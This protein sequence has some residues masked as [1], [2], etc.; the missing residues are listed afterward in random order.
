MIESLAGRRRWLLA[1]ALAAVA[2]ATASATPTHFGSYSVDD[3][4]GSFVIRPLAASFPNGTGAEQPARE[5]KI[6][7]KDLTIDNPAP[8][9]GGRSYLTLTRIK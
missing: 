3:K 9:S 8:S 7:G 6:T 4:D 2:C 1:A 5:L